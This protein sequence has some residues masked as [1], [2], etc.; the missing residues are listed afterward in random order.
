MSHSYNC[1][2]EESEDPGSIHEATF[3]TVKMQYKI[4]CPGCD[5][6]NKPKVFNQELSTDE[7]QTFLCKNCLGYFL[8]MTDTIMADCLVVRVN[9]V[10]SRKKREAIIPSKFITNFSNTT[11]V[12]RHLLQNDFTITMVRRDDG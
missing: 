8:L 5:F 12:L 6:I 3:D 7:Q 9:F 1:G 4:P 10:S 11:E 2:T